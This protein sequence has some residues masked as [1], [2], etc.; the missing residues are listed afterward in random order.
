MLTAF[1]VNNSKG[2]IVRLWPPSALSM[3]SPSALPWEKTPAAQLAVSW[4]G[5]MGTEGAAEA[6][7]RVTPRELAAWLLGAGTV[8]GVLALNMGVL[9]FLE[10]Q[11]PAWLVVMQVTLPSWSPLLT[12]SFWPLS[13]SPAKLFSCII[14][15]HLEMRP[16][17]VSLVIV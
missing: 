11:A 15:L 7:G 10:R 13:D 9:N 1:Q 5:G 4:L 17:F 6:E 2:K 12:D 14:L 3:S 8:P 16:V